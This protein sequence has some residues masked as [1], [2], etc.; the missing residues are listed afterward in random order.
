MGAWS[1]GDTKQELCV[2]ASCLEVGKC[3]FKERVWVLVPR[4]LNCRERC[5]IDGRAA[6]KWWRICFGG[7]L[8]AWSIGD[9]KQELCT[10]ASRLDAGKCCVTERSVVL[11]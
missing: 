4:P 8:G 3:R 6:Q 5:C 2:A 7:K 1:F 11:V 9:T 10:A